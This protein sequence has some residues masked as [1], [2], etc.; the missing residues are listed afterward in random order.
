MS[1]RRGMTLMEVILA[2]GLFAILALFV[3]RVLES[4]MGLWQAGERRGHGDLAFA[5][6]LDLLRSDLQNLHTG[7][8]GWLVLD[9][10][11]ALPAGEEHPAW[12]LP[13][14]R[15]LARGDGLT[16]TR[17]TGKAREILWMAVPEQAATSRL[18]RWVRYVQDEDP[19]ASLRDNRVAQRL[20]RSGAG[21]SVLDG[22]AWLAVRLRDT[23]GQLRRSV[24]IAADA[25]FDFP[26][27]LQLSLERVAGNARRRPPTLDETLGT[28]DRSLTLRGRPPWDHGSF[29]LVGQEWIRLQGTHPRYSAGERGAR[30]S[31]AAEHPAGTAVL[32]PRVYGATAEVA[33]GGRRVRP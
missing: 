12:L 13:R 25:P 31:V 26:P 33:A 17:G 29:A 14:L 11:E 8:R 4:V 30:D 16:D 22:V 2:L 28:N 9:E 27:R 20:A 24:A 5:A 3:G 18:T 10:W 21:L 7:P 23:D 6:A 32:L 1:R 19:A 15:F